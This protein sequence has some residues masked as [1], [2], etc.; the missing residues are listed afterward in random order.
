LSVCLLTPFVCSIFFLSYCLSVW[1]P[2]WYVQSFFYRIVCLSDYSFGMYN[3]FS[4]E[5][6]IWL[7]LWYV[8]SFFY[9]I[10]CFSDYSFGMFNLFSIVLSVCL[11]TPLVC[12]IFFL[13]YCLFVWLPLWYVQS[14]FYRIV[15]LS[16]YSF[17]MYNLFS[18]VLSVCL[19]T[20][21]VCSI[22][23]LSYCLSVWLPFGMFNLFSIV[24]SVCLI[25]PLVCTIF[26]LSYCL[27]DYSFG[28]FNLFSI[29]LSC[30]SYYS[31]VMFILFSIVLSVCLFIPLFCSFFFFLYLKDWTYQ[32]SN[33]IDNTIEK[34]LNIPKE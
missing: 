32:R 16:D 5:L 34:R 29:V 27:S 4:I 22:F 8:Q 25:T 15:C 19:I 9:R 18:I 10:V 12:S 31:F 11:I 24:L 23:F 20:P 7:L 13:S 14:F 33:Q 1:L 26:F 21:L 6:S 28:M 3:R 2:L 17:G 30:L